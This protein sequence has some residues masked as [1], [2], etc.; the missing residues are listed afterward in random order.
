MSTQTPDVPQVFNCTI[1]PAQVNFKNTQEQ[2]F[3]EL[4]EIIIFRNQLKWRFCPTPD[5]FPLFCSLIDDIK[6]WYAA[7]PRIVRHNNRYLRFD[8]YGRDWYTRLNTDRVRH[9]DMEYIDI[10]LGSS[11]TRLYTVAVVCSESS[12]WGK[13]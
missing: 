3:D 9:D 5:I 12:I 4:M 13:I 11:K 6:K 2:F 1:R 10:C 8:A 7:T